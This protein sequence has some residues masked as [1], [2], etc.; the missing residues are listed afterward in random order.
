MSDLT[1]ARAAE[2]LFAV[3]DPILP[4]VKNEAGLGVCERGAGLKIG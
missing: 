4:R 2:R 1:L 3:A